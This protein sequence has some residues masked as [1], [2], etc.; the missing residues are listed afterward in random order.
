MRFSDYDPDDPPQTTPSDESDRLFGIFCSRVTTA[1]IVYVIL[2]GGRFLTIWELGTIPTVVV[3][4]FVLRTLPP[5][6]QGFEIALYNIR[7][8]WQDLRDLF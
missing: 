4:V 1:V 8:A 5:F 3:S 7:L 6:V 2:T